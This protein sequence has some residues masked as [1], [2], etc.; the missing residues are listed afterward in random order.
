MNAFEPVLASCPWLPVIGN[1]ESTSGSGGDKV[2]ASA[3]EHYLNQTWGVVMDST[4]NSSLGHLLTKATAFSAGS[5][6]PL[7]SRTSQ[8]ASVDV[9]LIHFAVL[10]LD[11]GPPPIFADAQA[12]WLEADLI[13]AAANRE[14]VPWIVVGSHFPLYAGRFDEEG[15]VLFFFDRQFAHSRMSLVPTPTRLTRS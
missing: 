4:A 7:P 14:N 5:H 8:W 6:G 12:A 1:H 10:D 11:P 15:T 3:E 9:G 2:D 13:K